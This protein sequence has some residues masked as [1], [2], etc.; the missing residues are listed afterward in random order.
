[1][2]ILAMCRYLT[3]TLD[4]LQK[5]SMNLF[6]ESYLLFYMKI[7]FE[8]QEEIFEESD[9]SNSMKISDLINNDSVLTHLYQKMKTEVK[10]FH[11]KGNLDHYP[12]LR[13][14]CQ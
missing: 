4:R 11:I 10:S 14:H 7:D 9:E 13:V 5:E 6:S 2:A 8:E 3:N 12:I 1:M